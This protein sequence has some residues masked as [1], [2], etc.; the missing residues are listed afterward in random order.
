M[1]NNF[2]IYVALLRGINVG[3]N[4]TV[5]M[6]ILKEC[7]EKLGYKKVTT[8]INSGNVIFQANQQN[9]TLEKEIEKELEAKFGFPIRV[10]VRSFDEMQKLIKSIPKKWNKET[11]WRHNVIFLSH[12]IDNRDAFVEFIPK[13]NIEEMH[14]FPGVLLWSAKTSDLTKSNMLKVNK[15]PLYKEMTIRGINTT[16]KI[17]EIMQSLQ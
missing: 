9:R 6:A 5:S 8:Y 10:V 17:F 12:R 16:L 13:P 2:M 14:Y 1:Y 15:S 7:F 11:E 3:G 4:N